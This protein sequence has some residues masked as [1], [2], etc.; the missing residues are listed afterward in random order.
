MITQEKKYIAYRYKESKKVYK[1]GIVATIFLGCFALLISIIL[2]FIKAEGSDKKYKI[3][4]VCLM[5][6]CS[7]FFF[8]MIPLIQKTKKQILDNNNYPEDAIYFESGYI[9]ILT[10][11]VTKIKAADIT[12]VEIINNNKFDTQ[13]YLKNVDAQSGGNINIVTEKEKFF[14]PQLKNVEKVKERILKLINSKTY[15]ID[16]LYFVLN[17]FKEYEMECKISDK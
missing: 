9:C 11:V 15:I 13:T 7:I 12:K 17:A 2:M 1:N 14:V 8:C 3:I 4:V 6:F 16:D 5:L 10:D